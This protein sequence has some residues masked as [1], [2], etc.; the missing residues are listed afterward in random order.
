VWSRKRANAL[1]AAEILFCFLV[2]TVVMTL[3]AAVVSGWNRPLGFEWTNVWL[4]RVSATGT[5]A[6]PMADSPELRATITNLMREMKAFPQIV[7]SGLSDTPAYGNATSSGRWRLDGKTVSLTRDEVT[8]GFASVMQMKTTRGRWFVPSDDALNYTPVVIDEDLARDLYDAE[9]PIGKKFDEIDSNVFRVVGVV[10]PY[11]KSG[12]LSEPK[13][14]MLFTRKSL[15]K[16]SGRVPRNI[17]IRVRPGTAASFEAELTQRLHA[18]APDIAFNIEHMDALREFTIRSR[19]IPMTILGII[20]AFLI[21]MVAL[22]LSGVLWQTVTRRAPELGLRRALG[23]SGAQVRHQVL[24]EVALLATA[25]VTVGLVILLQ[26]P[27]LGV[28]A[29]V[30][31]AVFTTGIIAALAV[32]YAI[33]LLCGAYPSWL[34]ST[35]QPAEAL[36]YE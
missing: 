18:V 36:H 33:T 27:M 9:D 31:P 26:L 15:V 14:N 34:A 19:V 17:I 11:R 35:I 2:V 28:F 5:S 30:S 25:A 1:V 4:V 29:L 13:V 23:A 21:S 7:D 20:A 6:D 8:D 16:P 12:E 22:G 3:V 10:P 24:I 32:I